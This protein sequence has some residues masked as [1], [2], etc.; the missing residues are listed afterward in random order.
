MKTSQPHNIGQIKK[1]PDNKTKLQHL[2]EIP[3]F[4]FV[5]Y[6]YYKY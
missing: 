6:F 2:K 3:Q 1:T 4:T 5:K